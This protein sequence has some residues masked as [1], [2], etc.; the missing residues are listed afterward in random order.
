MQLLILILA[1]YRIARLLAAEPGPYDVF[2]RL[3]ALVGVGYDDLGNPYG[4]NEL[5]RGLVCLYCNSIWV[6]AVL[7][8][9]YY[10]AP[11]VTFWLC[12]PFALSGGAM[13]LNNLIERSET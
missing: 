13:V 8:L 1:T 4:S 6:G 9:A 11:D 7:A 3:R 5:A 10:L 2:G 12:L